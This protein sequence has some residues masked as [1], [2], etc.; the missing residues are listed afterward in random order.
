MS[1]MKKHALALLAIT[2]FSAAAEEQE[3]QDMSDP[4]AVYTQAGLGITDKGFNLK[5]GQTYDTGSDITMGMNIIEFKG[6]AGELLGIRDNEKPLFNSVDNSI[7]GFRFRNFSV[8]TENGRGSQ[9]DL[10]A[11]IDKETL[12]AS[13]SFIQALPKLSIF[14][15][16]PLAGVGLTVENDKNDGYKV[17]GAFAAVGFYGKITVTD[18]IW[19][20][21]NPLWLTT[22]SG[23]DSYKDNYY[24]GDSQILTHEFVASY[25]LSPR[26]NIRY[27]ANWNKAVDFADGD[28]RIEFNYQL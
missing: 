10:S 11:N 19:L 12:D 5:V 27:F 3:L 15:L 7:D 6:I 1:K 17:P 8:N 20:N 2:A 13:Y 4:L 23:S 21:Y 16:Y 28:H 24:A 25:Q 18:K 26:A 9:I 14:Q 22:V